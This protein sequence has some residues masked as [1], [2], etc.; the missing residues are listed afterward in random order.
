MALAAGVA[1]WLLPTETTGTTII[2]ILCREADTGCVDFTGTTA[3][4]TIFHANPN[5]TEPSTGTGVFIPFV[6]VH[7]S[8]G[9]N[10]R[11]QNGFNTDAGEPG[12][13]FDT[14]NGSDWT[15]SVRFDEVGIVM[16]DKIPFYV[17]QLDANQ[18]GSAQSAQNQITITDMQIYIGSDPNLANPEATGTGFGTGYTGTPFDSSDNFLLGLAPVWTLDSV[19]NG[20]VDVILQASICDSK[21]QCGSGHGDLDVFIPV[22]LL[23]GAPEDF[24]VLYTEYD[25]ANDGFEEWRFDPLP[26]QVPEPSTTLLFAVGLVLVASFRRR[27]AVKRRKHDHV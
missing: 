11:L 19:A 16:R 5:P 14:K 27:F 9:G 13:N 15:R 12:I 20:D 4:E 1:L 6:R 18:I 17:L 22:G 3:D 10:V 26:Q 21:G 7:R 25:G 23:S 2:S 8:T 24:F